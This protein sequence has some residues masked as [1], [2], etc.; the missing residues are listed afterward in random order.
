MISSS[1]FPWPA[2]LRSHRAAHGVACRHSIASA[3]RKVLI[4]GAGLSG[5]VSAYLLKQAGHRVTLLEARTR[6]GGRV[7]TAREPFA[8]GLHGELGPAR[9]PETHERIR[10]WIAHFGLELE[11]FDPSSGDRLDVVQGQMI[12]DRPSAPPDLDAFPLPFTAEEL[13]FGIAWKA[14]SNPVSALCSRST[15][16]LRE[17]HPRIVSIVTG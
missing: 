17:S 8:E 10:A 13:K 16:Q 14:R 15:A 1:C 6:P 12:R 3:H 5:L 9:I 2:W 4:V 7:L 11:R